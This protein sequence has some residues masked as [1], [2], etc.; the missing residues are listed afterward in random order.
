M[1]SMRYERRGKSEKAEKEWKSVKVESV[2]IE[3]DIR[4]TR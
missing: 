2:G 3:R 1:K 4:G